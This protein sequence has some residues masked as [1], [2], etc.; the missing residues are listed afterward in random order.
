MKKI[1]CILILGLLCLCGCY[2][3][4]TLP[5][6]LENVDAVVMGHA[7]YGDNQ[8]TVTTKLPVRG[9]DF[10]LVVTYDTGDMPLSDWRITANKSISMEAKT[11]GLPEGYEAYIEHVH[12]DICLKSTRERLNGISH[13]SM[14]DSDHRTPTKGFKI[15]DT[16]SYHNVFAIE[17]Y[18]N[19]FYQIWG[20]TFGEF[21]YTDSS[22]DRLEESNL[23][24][25]GVYAEELCVVYDI[26]IVKPDGSE[27][28]RSIYSE[29]LIPVGVAE[30][31]GGDV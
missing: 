28:V 16:D 26:V 18:N 10:T 7:G 27:C 25:W 14:D 17:G 15:S 13:D 8:T 29:V 9:E 6:E 12:A 22:Y 19:E 11:S 3:Y 1:S 5:N 2:D 20:Y 4:D 30:E 23:L 31:E 21:G 24:Y